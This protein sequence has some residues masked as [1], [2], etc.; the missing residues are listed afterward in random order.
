MRTIFKFKLSIIDSQLINVPQDFKPLFVEFQGKELFIWGEVTPNAQRVDKQ[1]FI[2]ETGNP[3]P[4]EDGSCKYI[5]SV[6]GPIFV[7]HVYLE[8]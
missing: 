3:I 7:W 4:F 2:V 5:D 1:V 8:R 6:V